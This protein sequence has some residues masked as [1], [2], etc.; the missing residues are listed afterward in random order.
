MAYSKILDYIIY[1]LKQLK[2]IDIAT[3]YKLLIMAV[4]QDAIINVPIN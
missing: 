2:Y 3:H 4:Y 1:A